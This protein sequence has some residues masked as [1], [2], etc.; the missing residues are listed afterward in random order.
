MGHTCVPFRDMT[1]CANE[2]CP[3]KDKC[4]RSY[5]RLEGLDVQCAW[6]MRAAPDANGECEYEL[7]FRK[8]TNGRQPKRSR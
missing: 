2:E 7:P 4:G 3:K 5:K 1:F 8:Y 6:W